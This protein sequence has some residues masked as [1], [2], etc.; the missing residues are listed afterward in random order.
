[1]KLTLISKAED[2]LLVGKCN[3]LSTQPLVVEEA[4]CVAEEVTIQEEEATQGA[5]EEAIPSTNQKI[6]SLHANC[7]VEPIIQFSSVISAL[8]LRTWEK[9][10]HS[11]FRTILWCGF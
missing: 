8:I 10:R 7:V 11:K 4:S 2:K 5:E 6:A 1:M 3:L 9:R